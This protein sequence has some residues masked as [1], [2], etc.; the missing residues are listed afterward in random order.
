MIVWIDSTSDGHHEAMGSVIENAV[1]ARWQAARSNP[2]RIPT[3]QADPIQ[4]QKPLYLAGFL[5]VEKGS[6]TWPDVCRAMPS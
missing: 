3:P 6:N 4:V 5:D 2:Q 1:P